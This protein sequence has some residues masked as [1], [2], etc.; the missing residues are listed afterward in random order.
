MGKYQ[1]GGKQNKTKK[2]E[3]KNIFFLHRENWIE[4]Q[5]ELKVLHLLQSVKFW[6]SCHPYDLRSNYLKRNANKNQK[7]Y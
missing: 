1:G 2:N 3:E 6:Y 4:Q 7:E 5:I